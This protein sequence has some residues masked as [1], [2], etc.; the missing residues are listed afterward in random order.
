MSTPLAIVGH[1]KMGRLIEELAGEFDFEVRARFRSAD[2]DSVSAATLDGARTAMEFST[3]QAAPRNLMRLAVSSTDS[4]ACGEESAGRRTTAV[5]L[6]SVK[7]ELSH[8]L[9]GYG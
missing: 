3:P 9:F 4:N 2:I 1:G 7:Q 8:V 5:Q 6:A